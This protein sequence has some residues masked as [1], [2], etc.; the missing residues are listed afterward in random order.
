MK[1]RLNTI[2]MALYIVTMLTACSKKEDPIY[3]PAGPFSNGAFISNEGTFG[4]ANASVSFYDY[5]G[6]SV[7]NS[8]F[9]EVNKFQLGQVLQSMYSVNGMA[10]MILNLSDTVVIA[11]MGD[12]KAA[13]I[14]TGLSS[15]RYMTSFNNKGYISQWGSGGLIKV[16][17]LNTNSFLRTI[18]VGTGPEQLIV[19]GGNILVCNGGAYGLDSTI[20]VINPANDKVV[21]TIVVGDNPKEL[22]IDKNNDIWVLCFGYIQYDGNFNII[23]ETPSKLVKISGQSFQKMAEFIISPNQHPQHIDISKDKSTVYYGGGFGYAGIYA[24]SISASAAPL[25]PLIDGS[26]FFYGFNV[27][28]GNGEVYAL[29]AK[30]FTSPGI[31]SRFTSQGN[32]VRE[33][34]AGIAPNGALF[35]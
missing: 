30:D 34:E 3:F 14:I 28:P 5:A 16:F 9:T 2:L 29:D 12:F 32:L 31:L 27:N 11:N 26:K 20:S 19:S 17:D 25:N 7:R 24:M 4:Q 18:D 22:V 10:Y 8:I 1:I 15:P 23:L 6:D 21:K 33:Y 13:G 35:N